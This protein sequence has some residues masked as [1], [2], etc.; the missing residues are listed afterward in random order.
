[1]TSFLDFLVGNALALGVVAVVAVVAAAISTLGG[2]G[3][4]AP[5]PTRPVATAA[6]LAESDDAVAVVGSVDCD[7][8]LTAPFVEEPAVAYE[9]AV[10]SRLGHVATVGADTT[11]TIDVDG[12]PVQVE[13][14]TSSSATPVV[15]DGRHEHRRTGVTHDEFDDA[16]VD[17]LAAHDATRSTLSRRLGGTVSPGGAPRDYRIRCASTSDDVAVVGYLR[18]DADGWTLEPRENESLRYL[19]PK[20]V[21]RDR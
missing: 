9:V 20:T 3:R 4:T 11:F 1:M 21:V 5:R 8:P 17:A 2:N 6:D 7:A 10:S 19:D 13:G 18:R 14:G 15:D 12:E 16:T